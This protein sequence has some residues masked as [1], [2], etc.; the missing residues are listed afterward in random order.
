MEKP[1]RVSLISFATN[2]ATNSIKMTGSVRMPRGLSL[3]NNKPGKLKQNIKNSEFSIVFLT[4]V[5]LNSSE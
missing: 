5:L 4:P 2:S 3:C 1:I